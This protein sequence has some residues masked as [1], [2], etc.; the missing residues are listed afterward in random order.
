MKILHVAVFTERSTNVWQANAF[1]ELGHQVIRYDYRQKARDLDGSLTSNNV[2]RDND[3]INL[4][5]REC[6]DIILFSKCNQ[7][8]VRVVTACNKVGV[9][10]L[11]FMDDWHN[12]NSELVEKIKECNYI[13]CSAPSGIAEANKYKKKVY[14]LQ[15]GYASKVHYPI[16]VPKNRDVCFIGSIHTNRKQFKD[17]VNFKLISGVYN[18]KHSKIVS[19]TKINLNFTDG[20]GVSNRVYKILAAKGFLLSLPWKTVE[21]DFEVGVDLVI[22]KTPE[23]LKEKI[24]YYLK[25]EDERETIAEHGYKTVQKYDDHNYAKRILEVINA[26]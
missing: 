9:T 25:H 26:V 16:N 3:L 1:E 17:K 5:N 11:W 22:F 24:K 19:G 8:D 18:K 7:M 14:R 13:F 10:I 23:E 6:P 4:C 20:D 12:I 2:K 15:G 21:E